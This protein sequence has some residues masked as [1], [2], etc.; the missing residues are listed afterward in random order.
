MV[1]NTTGSRA[2]F[3]LISAFT[4]LLVVALVKCLNFSNLYV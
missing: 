2:V 3:G 1:V 4:V